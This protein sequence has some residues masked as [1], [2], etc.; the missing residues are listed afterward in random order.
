MT[1]GWLVLST[2]F[3]SVGHHR[4]LLWQACT[5]SGFFYVAD[6]GVDEE[7][8]QATFEQCRLVFSLPEVRPVAD[9]TKQARVA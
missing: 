6:H 1:T 3:I 5:T 8:V 2:C 7:L 4:R 9:A